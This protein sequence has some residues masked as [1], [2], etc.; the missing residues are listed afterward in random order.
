[1]SINAENNFQHVRGK[2]H[3]RWYAEWKLSWNMYTSHTRLCTFGADSYAQWVLINK[4]SASEFSRKFIKCALL[5]G[6]VVACS[7][8]Q[9]L[10]AHAG[11]SLNAQLSC[12]A[13]LPA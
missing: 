9:L 6:Y 11:V 12:G 5:V 2:N 10:L 7:R 3:Q 13:S 1:M 4:I 8:L